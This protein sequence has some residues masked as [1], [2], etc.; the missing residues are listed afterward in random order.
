[1]T[2]NI[3]QSIPLSREE[4]LQVQPNQQV[5][6]FE[7]STRRAYPVPYFC[8]NEKGVYN[9]NAY[10]VCTYHGAWYQVKL[11]QSTGEPVLGEPALGIH[12][13]D[14]EAQDEQSQQ[15]SDDKQ[16]MDL[17]DD[18]I[19]RSPVTISPIQAS[20]PIMSMMR[21]S[22]VITVQ[23]GGSNALPSRP[24]TPP[25]TG[26]T[27]L[28]SLQSRLNV[29]LRRTGPPGE[30]GGP[31]GPG[32][33]SRPGALR[34]ALAPVQVLQQ[35]VAPAGNVKMMGQLPQIFTGDCSKAD[36]FIE[37]VKGYLHLNQDVA[38]FD[39]PIKKIAFPLTLI[40]GPDTAG[41]TR[42]MGNFLDGLR[43][44]DN[45][46]DL[47]MQFLEEFR[48]QFQDMQKEDRAQVQLEGFRMHFPEIDMYITKFEELARQAGYT[49][50]NSKTM[51]TFIKGLMPS[52]MEDVLKPLH[53]QG[54]HVI[55]QKA[56]ECTWSR[57][58]LD[59]IL[60]ARQPRGRGFQGGM[61]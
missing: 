58:L 37:E 9:R 23:V 60:R 61:F 13:Y 50:G 27:T 45:I 14:I 38:G 5:F 41:W 29:A 1:M 56:I 20:V 6:R 30:G 22:P 21:T 12:A 8:D 53:A 28:A 31:G 42:D 2:S 55:K 17:I 59:N 47:W 25:Q 57:V 49:A 36:N 33:P 54:Y 4:A 11:D 7:S 51:H 52:V 32:G 24:G 16:Q 26:G 40:K 44:A 19:R 35:P 18:E 15:S 10:A 48:Q 39:L 46:L 3:E 34:G 43:P